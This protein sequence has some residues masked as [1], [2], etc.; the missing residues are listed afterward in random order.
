MR[1]ARTILH[2][3]DD[4]VSKLRTRT[5]TNATPLQQLQ[6]YVERDLAECHDHAC[7][8]QLVDLRVQVI[9]TPVISS[10]TG[11]LSGGAHRTAA[12]MHVA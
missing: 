6:P 2:G 12:T 11:L 4:T 5:H 8:R 1:S 10:G 3:D 9:E 7:M